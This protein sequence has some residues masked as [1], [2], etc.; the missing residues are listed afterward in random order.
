MTITAN[1]L[2]GLVLALK[3]SGLTELPLIKW[4]RQ[5]YRLNGRWH[6]EVEL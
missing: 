2:S 6:A 3:L 1:D 4:K 5:P